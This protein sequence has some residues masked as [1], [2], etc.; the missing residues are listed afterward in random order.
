MKSLNPI[1]LFLLITSFSYSQTFVPPF[2]NPGG[3]INEGMVVKRDGDTIQGKFLFIF[4][5]ENIKKITVKDE[6]GTK[7]KLE[8]ED[9]EKVFIRIQKSAK[10]AAVDQVTSVKDLAQTDFVKIG[11]F[12]YYVYERAVTPKK[13]K[14][15]VMQLVNLGFE[16]KLKVYRNPTSG[17]TGGI[18]IKGVKLTGGIEKSYYIVKSGAETATEVTKGKYKNQFYDIFVAA[19][20]EM[21]SVL[22][23]KKPDWDDFPMHVYKYDQ[24]CN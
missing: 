4:H 8:S 1:F 5:L 17:E 23:G 16:S 21:E 24:L 2:S 19:C 10:Y 11:E 14:P 9:I 6:E 3:K 13:G 22:D 20:P 7:H 15:K 12:E 18:K